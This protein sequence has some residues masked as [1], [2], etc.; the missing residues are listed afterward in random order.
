M[1]CHEA[2]DLIEAIA[3]GDAAPPAAFTAH[4]ESCRDC[5]G[6]LET[7]RALERALAAQPQPAAPRDFTRGVVATIRRRRWEYDEQVDRVFNVA[8]VA[9][10]ALVVVAIVGLLNASALA[11]MLMAAGEALAELPR[12]SPRWEDVG[13]ARVAGIG[14]TVVL[15][16]AAVWWW[17][18]R[19]SDWQHG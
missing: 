7:A 1:T 16:A 14:M 19:R 18:E 3:T 10:V 8:I 6:A 11:Q 4:V 5:A 2:Q 12:E 17:A 15:T 9:G 13:T